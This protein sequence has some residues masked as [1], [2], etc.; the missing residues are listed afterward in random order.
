[1]KRRVFLR[2]LAAVPLAPLALRPAVG[3]GFTIHPGVHDS[4]LVDL[5]RSDAL[6]LAQLEREIDRQLRLMT[7]PKWVLPKGVAK[8][9]TTA[10][11]INTVTMATRVVS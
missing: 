8:S 3:P 4:I 2:A 7:H 9:E 1:M 5:H 11:P 6:T 10:A